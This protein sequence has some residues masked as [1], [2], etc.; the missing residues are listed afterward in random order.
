MVGDTLI[1]INIV[2][3]TVIITQ[4]VGKGKW[5][6]ISN[7][8]KFIPNSDTIL[9]D[10]FMFD[11]KNFNG[12]KL[13]LYNTDNYYPIVYNLLENKSVNETNHI[14][15]VKF[16]IAGYSIGD[17][18]NRNLLEIDDVT[19]YDLYSIE[20]GELKSNDDIDIELIGS[21]YV[22]KITQ[23]DVSEYDLE[24]IMKV[25]KAKLGIEPKHTPLTK[26]KEYEQE[27]YRWNKNG[28]EITLQK[29]KYI[30]N[31]SWKR[32]YSND[33][34][35]LYYEDKI[36]ESLLINEFKNTNPKSTIIN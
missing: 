2:D 27:Y 17:T 32:L 18:I 5:E 6:E 11:F 9:T 29:M 36:M 14:D 16:E 19:N 26:G 24:D 4:I 8:Y 10:T 13:L 25:V 3:S 22:F 15:N 35:T 33:G 7:E 20:E 23:H 1:P 34:W 30:G 28:V 21:M 12:I 31:D